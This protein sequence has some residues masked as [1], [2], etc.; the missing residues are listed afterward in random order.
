M[1]DAVEVTVRNPGYWADHALQLAQLIGGSA[2]SPIGDPTGKAP[3]PE[4]MLTVVGREYWAAHPRELQEILNIASADETSLGHGPTKRAS[5]AAPTSQER[6]TLTVEEAA[7]A[8]G[9][10]RAFAYESVRRG[11]IPHIRI[12]R[13][14]LVPRAALE[15]MLSSASPTDA[16]PI[17]PGAS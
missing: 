16:D 8:L 2:I 14:L 10:S 15:H 11:D 12:G 17:P 7:N 1:T 3:D 5:G 6:L 9:I 4:S 13:R